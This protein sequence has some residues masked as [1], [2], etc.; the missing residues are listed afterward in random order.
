MNTDQRGRT[1][2]T[3]GAAC[4]MGAWEG[5]VPATPAA[6]SL[7]VGDGKLT[8]SVTAP[9]S[10]FSI[11]DY[12]VITSTDD[13]NWSAAASAGSN[14]SFTITGLT[15][16][17]LYYVKVRAKNVAGYS[18]WSD[19]DSATPNVVTA[20]PDTPSAPTLTAG[21]AQLSASFTAPDA[22]NSP[23]T[24]YTYRYS[25]DE[26][27]W[28]TSSS[29]TETSFTI[30]GLT[31]GT[32]YYVQVRAT[33][34]IGDSSW[35]SSASA[36]PATTPDTP[37]APTLTAGNLQLTGSITAPDNNGSAI[38]GYKYRYSTDE[39]AWTTS[40]SFT[41]TSFT[42]T[43]LSNGTSYYV[44]IMATNGAGDSSWSSSASATPATTPSTP[45]APS[46]TV[47]NLQLTGSI[48]APASNGSAIT[49]YTY[50]YSTDESSWTTSAS[51]TSTSFTISSLTNGTSYYVQVMAT[52][53]VGD[54][55]WSSSASATPATTP[56]T[57]GAPALTVASRQLTGN[58]TAPASNGSAI[59]G[60][61][62]R[63]STDESSWTTSSSFTE[64]SFSITGLTNGSSYYVQVRATNGVGDSSWSSS[65][66]ATP[67]AGVINV[68]ATCSL[69]EAVQNANDDAQTN[70][71][72]NA[73]DGNDTIVI[74]ADSSTISVSSAIAVTS[75][76]T[77]KGN[78]NTVDGGGSNRLF[79]VKPK[80]GVGGNLTIEN[81][82][83]QNGKADNH[84]GAIDV[85]TNSSLTV[86]NSN[87]LN[88]STG[89]TGF[90]G[91]IYSSSAT[92]TISNS[93][94]SGN[95][96]VSGGG[97]LGNAGGTV[98]ITNSTFSGNTA[99]NGGMALDL[100]NGNAHLNYLT[101]VGNS[102]TSN[103]STTAGVV[104]NADVNVRLH[105]SLLSGNNTENGTA[106]DCYG[107]IDSS[108]SNLINDAASNC[109]GAAS[110]TSDPNLGALADGVYPL[111]SSSPALNAAGCN[112]SISVDQRGESRATSGSD[113]DIGA[114][115]GQLPAKPNAPSLTAADGQLSVVLTA[116]A[117]DYSITDYDVRTSTDNATWGS[118][119]ST[120]NTTSFIIGSLTNGTTYY[121]QARAESALGNGA[122][123]DAASATPNPPSLNDINID[124]DCQIDEAVENANDDA[125]TNADCEAGSGHDNI[126][127]PAN[128]DTITLSSELDVSSLI[129]VTGNDNTI[130]GDDATRIFNIA[131][132]GNLTL[133]DLTL[134]NGRVAGDGAAVLV[135]SGGSLTATGIV[136][137]NNSATGSGNGGAIHNAGAVAI[138]QSALTVNA[139]GGD[140]GAISTASSGSISTS[141]RNS[142][143]D[144]N[145]G[146][147][148]GMGIYIQ[149]GG[150]VMEYLTIA[151]NSSSGNAATAAGLTVESGATV[152]LRN[153]ILDGNTTLNS[154]ARDCHGA[155]DNASGNLINDADSTCS[156]AASETDD[157]GLGALV[158][159]AYELTSSSPALNAATCLNSTNVDQRGET[160]ATTGSACDMGAWEAQVPDNP[161]A[162]SITAGDGTLSVTITAPDENDFSITDYEVRSSTDNSNWGDTAST[163]NATSFDVAGLT[164]GTTYYLQARAKSAAGFS[165]WSASASGT[166]TAAA[167]DAPAAPTLTA[168]DGQ[169]SGSITAPNANGSAITGYDYRYRTGSGAWTVVD[170]SADTTFTITGLTNGSGYEVQA[171]AT[172][173]EGDG[174]W[175]DSGTA[176]PGAVPDTPAAPS[177]AAGNGIING[178]IT[179]PDNNGNAITGY[180]YRYRTGS[181]AWTVV[182]NSTSTSFTITGLSN[183]N[184]YA[185]QVRASNVKGDSD[186]S[187]SA[188]VRPSA[189]APDTPAAPGLAS[190]NGQLTGTITAPNN[191]GSAIT[192]YDYRYRTGSNN[193][194]SAVSN[195]SSTSF[196]I[197]GLTNGT[198]YEVQVR[199]TNSVGT[200]AWS[201]SGSEQPAAAAPAAPAAPTLTAGNG[202]ISGSFTAPN[203]NGSAITGYRY[204][205]STDESNWTGQ[206]ISATSFTITGLTNGTTYYVQAR[207]TNSVGDS[208]WS[209][210]ASATAQASP[211]DAPV[212]PALSSGDTEISG[213]IT[214]PNNN[215][216][217]ITRYDYRYRRGNNSW[218]SAVDNSTSTSFTITSLTNGSSYDVQV[219]ATNGAG[220]SS[221]STS[222]SATPSTTPATPNSPD[223]TGGNA[224]ISGTITAPNNGG[225]DITG[226]HYRY[227]T[228]SNAWTEVSIGNTRSFTID[229]LTNGTTYEVQV[230][231][232]NDNGD[233]DWSDASSEAPVGGVPYTPDAPSISG[234]GATISGSF[235]APDN[236]GSPITGYRIRWSR[237]ESSW[238]GRNT[239]DTSF[240]I[241]GLSR[242]VTW[243]V[244]A[245]ASNNNGPGGWSTSAS[246]FLPAPVNQP[247]NNQ[248]NQRNDG[249]SGSSSE[250]TAT[251]APTAIPT[252]TG[253]ILNQAGYNVSATY[254]LESGAHFKQLTTVEVGNAAVLARGFLDAIDVF[255][256][257]AQGVTVCFP[258]QGTIVFL[259]AANAPRVP[260][261]Y[262]SYVNEEGMTCADITRAGSLVL[263]QA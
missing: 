151:Y 231:A 50:R 187:S 183:G 14:T 138:S 84:G 168:G 172:N 65:T 169:I 240:T 164:G 249:G 132:G 219:R 36:T 87:F 255:G 12:E 122:W 63:Y 212:A 154:T 88:N 166:P 167:P 186:W 222:A 258:Q 199:A 119:V 233:G 232:S 193:W 253:M 52:N 135:N 247:G 229:N 177:L 53:G 96:G 4:D 227:R 112:S 159:D 142:T 230:R 192:R 54:S 13:T 33:N 191:N 89:T 10:D 178:S 237:N 235:T 210:S 1:R 95:S 77:I 108:S 243:Y 109:S 251:P 26:S 76:L 110:V 16:G 3:T 204:R 66:S 8:V 74:P 184:T 171:R 125:A 45:S 7:T 179:A 62:Y 126:I 218:S 124:T 175:S 75:T 250:P 136:F 23:I 32:S 234:S 220:T 133:K 246:V 261:N 129:T 68:T 174:D 85:S 47:G 189:A 153:S 256:F 163:S 86:K 48:T 134:R 92:T 226:Y 35:S 181:G 120:S 71:D 185:V 165:G 118:A 59:T 257:V 158:N 37:S 25:T 98:R 143:I 106:R 140:G 245:R 105:R 113:C 31:N 182:D 190:G 260:E 207:A 215:G 146:G 173:G 73:G 116:P 156:A 69:A 17:T 49:G 241:T 147:S 114:W 223:L 131:S 40:S 29:F 11:T 162:P 115:E 94:F 57:P 244:Q 176:S 41:G 56:S 15:N 194:S 195:G 79:T 217:A 70:D 137:R 203:D 78:G 19:S 111:N 51:F 5:Q 91:A 64:T 30:T 39:S 101:I 202:Q 148:K 82:T 224:D 200:S 21:N 188:S 18:G 259:D 160:R 93:F 216:G 144:Y 81:L 97:A 238:S 254:G 208:A 149:H 34:A 67:E 44:Q 60:Y 139:S 213:A 214:A 58:L 72:C 22:N 197:T 27:T 20:V 198:S 157:S 206:N 180:D 121:V 225:A 239:T 130:S 209:A 83:L 2:A 38:T 152:T 100:Y 117:S 262:P 61:N 205:Y 55:S 211:P 104:T 196:T 236:G 103:G 127:I 141:I 102:S 99:N 161:S 221:W 80:S 252:P 28:T 42:I 242:G 43:G 6:P 201:D 46:L 150:A 170:N 123:S 24:G 128:N 107:P 248:G 90:G 228:G 155:I 145:N 9:A 263:V